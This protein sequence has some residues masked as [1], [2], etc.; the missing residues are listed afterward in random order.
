MGRVAGYTPADYLVQHATRKR[1]STL[2]P[3]S[4]WEALAAATLDHDD[5]FRLARSADSLQLHSHAITLYRRLYDAGETAASERLFY[6]FTD[7]GDTDGLRILADAGDER[8]AT[9]L[10][11]VT[12][13]ADPHG[14]VGQMV[15]R[16]D[17]FGLRKLA[18]AGDR[19]ARER[20]A[21]VLADR[22]E[23]ADAIPILE[24]R[25]DDGDREA[26]VRLIDLL[27]DY[28]DFDRLR[29]LA[30]DG[31]AHG[32]ALI[33]LVNLLMELGDQDRLR[34]LAGDGHRYAMEQ[35]ANLLHSR[36]DRHGLRELALTAEYD[37]FEW[38]AGLLEDLN[39]LD[40]AAELRRLNELRGLA[41]DGDHQAVEQLANLL[42][43]RADRDG[44]RKL[45]L[46]V[47]YADVEWLADL[48]ADL[49][50]LEG[51]ADVQRRKGGRRRRGDPLCP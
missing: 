18:A 29:E 24:A 44:L 28:R 27:L 50:D 30:A 38:L 39:D 13:D 46:R 31:F 9:W 11:V 26:G 47:D 16:G 49:G 33:G 32:W 41:Y 3:A 43:D 15:K 42:K 17:I 7:S 5:T 4:T 34:E 14:V 51:A 25:A 35:L 37:D 45:A 6:L 10:A 2:I 8:A 23:I 36:A 12:A 21:F 22:G 19:Y 1:S 40:G 48:L 20:L